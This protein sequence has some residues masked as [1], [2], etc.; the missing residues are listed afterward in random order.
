MDNNPKRSIAAAED[1]LGHFPVLYQNALQKRFTAKIGIESGDTSDWSMVENL[2]AAMADGEA[3]FT[4]VFRHLP[5][6][7]ESGNAHVVAGLFNQPETL[8]AWLSTWRA[9]L[10]QLDRNEALALMRRTNPVFIPRNHRIEEAIQ[11][12]NSGDFTL[13]RQLHQILQNP[14]TEQVEFT[15]YEAPPTPAEVVRETFCG[16]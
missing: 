3:D 15:E 7:L 14:F 11:A 2:L 9:R 8:V 4:Q 10:H 5:E 12:G 16:T 6:S 13:F 1:A